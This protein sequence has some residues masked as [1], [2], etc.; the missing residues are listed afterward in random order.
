MKEY[1][2]ALAS[3]DG[4][5]PEV[6]AAA[7]RVL[8]AA[9][10]AF[11]FGL[12]FEECPVG[13]AAYDAFG[14]PLPE[15]SLKIMRESDAT[16]LGAMS[17][18]LVPPPSPMGRLRREL[19][20]FADVRVVKSYPGVWS[21]RPEIDIVCIRENM[22]GFLADRNLFRGYGEFMPTQDLV[23]SMRV[24]SRPA[25]LNVSR[26][27]F[28]F[29]RRQ[30]RR[31]IT[32]VHKANA[33]RWGESFFLDIVRE[34]A[35]DYP[36][37]EL[38]DEYVDSVANH[39]IS[40]PGRY[41]I[42]LA[43][44]LYGDILSDEAAALVSGLVPTANVGSGAALFRPVHEAMTETAGK[45][46]ADPLSAILSGGMMLRHLGE[47]RAADAVDGAV[48]GLLAGGSVLPRDL[49][50]KSTTEEVAAGVCAGFKARGGTF[51]KDKVGKLG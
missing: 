38:D 32:A 5:G 37:I 47:L 14:D 43:T 24:L 20:L 34:T 25:L 49:G 26:Y 45:N 40:D 51:L 39:L 2:I 4:V 21:L 23:L 16:L 46:T 31:K 12:M 8:E 44:N 3:G 48:S 36:E 15:R 50:G 9:G 29:A 28:E 13:K 30:K 33:L 11:G 42:L 6:T 1:R 10:E 41:D 27:A 35:K 19:E 17:T 7:R 22:E 18:G